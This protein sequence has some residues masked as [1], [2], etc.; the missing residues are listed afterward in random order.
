LYVQGR[1]KEKE[2]KL[3]EYDTYKKYSK[4]IMLA[5]ESLAWRIREVLMFNGA[6]LLPDAP[7]NGFFKYKFESTVYR[8]CALIGWIKAAQK[9]HSYI[10]GY[11]NNKNSEI[12]EAINSFQ[13]VLAD[14]SH[15]E[16]S[17]YEE[18]CKLYGLEL[19]DISDQKRQ[20]IGVEIEKIVFKHIPDQV[21]KDVSKLD[22]NDKISMISS[23]MGL[24][25]NKTNQTILDKDIL[26]ENLDVAIDEIAR[27][28]C[29]I[30]R[31][32]QNAIGD[33][34]LIPLT[35][36]YRYFDVLGFSEFIPKHNDNDWLKKVDNLFSNLDVSIDDRFDNR[37]SQVKLIYGSLINLINKLNAAIETGEAISASGL[38]TL[39][40][41]NEQIKTESNKNR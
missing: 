9:E 7:D 19:I 8:L 1:R 25:S 6:Y 16:V 31:D 33:E 41:F 34:M 20:E 3:N 28:F 22:E 40:D 10:E 4:P 17:I 26:R 39:Q 15:V 35:N 29:W 38:K 23:I 2:R 30:Y 12:R 11:N 18:L 36:S 13:K 32:W 14:G 21:K 24:I 27:E 5:S 37:V